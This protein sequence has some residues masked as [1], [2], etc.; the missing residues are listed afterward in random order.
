MNVLI[1]ILKLSLTGVCVEIV[2]LIFAPFLPQVRETFN[3][4]YRS[5]Q[6]NYIYGVRNND[7]GWTLE[8]KIFLEPIKEPCN[9]FLSWYQQF[10]PFN[11][12]KYKPCEFCF[13]FQSDE[14][15]ELWREIND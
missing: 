11:I 5:K 3:H 2:S 4:Y 9:P 6:T 14:I 8:N 15:E 7:G 13:E 12:M 1:F 10:V